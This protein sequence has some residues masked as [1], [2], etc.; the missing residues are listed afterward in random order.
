MRRDRLLRTVRISARLAGEPD[1]RIAGAMPTHALRVHHAALGEIRQ[2]Q[3]FQEQI[4]EFVARQREAEIVLA[5]AVRAAFRASAAGAALRA[6]DGVAFDVLLVAGQQMVA[7]A[8][9][10]GCDGTMARA[11]PGRAGRPRRLDRRP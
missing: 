10:S 2:F 4:D 7:H 11:R 9:T 5:L 1:D 6:R 3:V 8:A